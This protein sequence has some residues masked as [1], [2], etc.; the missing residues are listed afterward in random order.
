MGLG[1]RCRRRAAV[2]GKG[3]FS[4]IEMMLVLGLL[5]LL[6]AITLPVFA[7]HRRSHEFSTC[8]LNLKTIGQ[9]LRMYWEDWLGFPWD[10]TEPVGKQYG[11]Q[12]IKGPGL[13]YL[14][15]LYR[16]PEA[17]NQPAQVKWWTNLQADYGVR[18]LSILHCPAN[19]VD[20]PVLRRPSV[21]RPDPTLG[22]YNNYDLYYR[23]SW[24]EPYQDLN[25]NGLY[26][27]GEPFT[28][29]N[30]NG[31]HDSMGK[32]SLLESFPQDETV[33]TWCPFHR[34][35]PPPEPDPATGW[36]RAGAVRPGEE[37]LVLWV[38][39]VVERVRIGPQSDLQWDAEY[40]RRNNLVPPPRAQET[41]QFK[42][43]HIF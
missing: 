11:G 13:F 12:D 19:P 16:N 20:E 10:M 35:A 38:D 15:Y 22:G 40:A 39:G 6:V 37:D 17:G 8:A 34:G 27:Q 1:L 31:R 42:A 7:A 18:R 41:E 26:D 2:S 33:V 9:G 25:G 36:P 3:G 5:A 21:S 28:D 23:R 43:E 32:R 29:M 4:L 30:S 24:D 14:Y